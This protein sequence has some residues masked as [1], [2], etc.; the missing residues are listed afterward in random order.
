MI[1]LVDDVQLPQFMRTTD[2]RLKLG[3][4]NRAEFMLY[5]EEHGEYCQYHNGH[6]HGDVSTY[7]NNTHAV[8]P[9]LISHHYFLSYSKVE[10]S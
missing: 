5:D 1:C 9:C 3:D 7:R 8:T 6:G 2:G 4:F 10:S